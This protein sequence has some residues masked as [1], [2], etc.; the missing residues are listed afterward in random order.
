MVNNTR[1]LSAYSGTPP[2]QEQGDRHIADGPLY[3]VADV[4]ALLD[5]GEAALVP[6][7]RKCKDDLLRL[8]LDVSDA[9]ALVREALENGCYRNS[10]WCVQQPSGPWAACD[11]Y[12]LWHNEW[13]QAA[14][15]E[16]C[17]E[18]YIKFAIGKSGKLLLLVSC[19]EPQ[20]RG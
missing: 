8:A 13:V 7:T 2:P 19:H 9:Q 1:N 17:F 3:H 18:Y 6:W 5:Q 15:K 16:M 12:Q 14:Y 11:A 4:L 10:E 20:D